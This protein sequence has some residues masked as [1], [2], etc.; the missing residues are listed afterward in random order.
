MGPDSLFPQRA[1]LFIVYLYMA[2]SVFDAV[3]DN[4]NIV[5]AL[6]SLV[7]MIISEIRWIS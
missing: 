5:P 6:S 7:S 1:C 2:V 4:Y 3:R